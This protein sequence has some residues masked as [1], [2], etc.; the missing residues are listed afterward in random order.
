MSEIRFDGRVAVITG[1]GGG[2]GKTY[3]LELARRGA[4]VVVNDLGGAPD[5]SGKSTSMADVTV[6]EIKAA[7]GQAV[8]SY[9]SVATPAGGE[10]IIKKA[11]DSFGR[12]DIVINNAGI[13]RDK[14]FLKLEPQDLEI[15][16]DVHLKG[17]F[18]VSQP[19]YRVMKE[20]NY[21]RFLFTASA[22]GIFGNFGQTNYGAA[23]MGLVGLSNVL[24]VEG[25]KNGI[26]SNVIAP[27]ARTR[28]TENLL[29]PIASALDPSTVM[30]LACYLV[31]EACELSHEVFSVGG[32]RFARVFVG[33]AP[34]WFA[35]KGKVVS[36]EDVRDN[37][38]RIMDEKNYIVP[39]SVGDEMR[40]IAKD[41]LG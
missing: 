37:L 25:A 10:A 6:N 14:S 32:G 12:V 4:H 15:V 23:K 5:G 24:A 7:G 35:G 11:I 30:P 21:G 26:K 16:L 39:K 3:A 19:A 20:Q 40:L 34:G 27:I 28:L 8:A 18:Y 2:L 33:L 22:A 31:S 36:L 29:G 9:D 38:G 13:L 41:L 17:A 1:A